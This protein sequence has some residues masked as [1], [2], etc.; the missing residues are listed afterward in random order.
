MASST[1]L[2]KTFSFLK[3]DPLSIHI[4]RFQKEIYTNGLIMPEEITATLLK[5]GITLTDT[6]RDTIYSKLKYRKDSNSSMEK[7]LDE[8]NEQTL[9]DEGKL[10]R[11][12]EKKMSESFK[13]NFIAKYPFWKHDV[14]RE[15]GLRNNNFKFNLND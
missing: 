13:K 12:I 11:I 9:R 7:K 14:E 6:D 5:E 4:K 10:L 2:S 15:E 8:I 1:L 3:R